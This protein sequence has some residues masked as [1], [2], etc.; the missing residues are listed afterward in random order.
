[1]AGGSNLIGTFE[2]KTHLSELL[3]R[4]ADG[5]SFVI[6]RR[7][8]PIAQLV[9]ARPVSTPMSIDDLLAA[10]QALR[11]EVRASGAEIRTWIE[12]GR[13]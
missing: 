10:A 9:P 6:T 2:A 1:M 7:G 5:E 8:R 11:A 13:D 4:V 3:E 12:E